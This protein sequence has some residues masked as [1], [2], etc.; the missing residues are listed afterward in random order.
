MLDIKS[1][2]LQLGNKVLCKNL[3][4]HCQTGEFWCFMGPNGS[5]KTT[6]LQTIAG[7]QKPFHGQVFLNE[8]PIQ[9]I[10]AKSRAKQIGILLQE[11]ENYLT[12]TVWDTLWA[13]RHPHLKTWPQKSTTKEY[14]II[15]KSLTTMDLTVYKQR[16]IT[17]LSGGEY[18]RLQ[19]A[20]LLTQDPIVYLLDEPTNHLDLNYQIKTLQFLKNLAEL[21]HKL[22]IVILHDLNLAY[23]F[24]SHT[25]LFFPEGQVQSGR[26]NEIF[27]IKNLSVLYNQPIEKIISG[28]KT[29][30]LCNPDS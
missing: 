16:L 29:V 27:T 30:W 10:P 20:M 1:L 8:Q 18:Q 6:L 2:T 4:L 11:D 24:A 22:V 23:Q 3:S 25:C 17:S 26:I 15:E 5:G 28:S 21:H 7:L 13:A 14:E 19:I 12:N 9:Q